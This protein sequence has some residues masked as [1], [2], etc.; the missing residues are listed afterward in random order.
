MN[1]ID[2][3][4][5]IASLLL[6]LITGW[7]S[8]RK[9]NNASDFL[10]AGKS[11]NKIQAGFSMASTDFGGSGLVAA[12]GYCYVVGMSG[13]WWNL[14]AAPAFVL[15]GIFLARQFNTLDGSTL[16]EFLGNRYSV[17]VKNLAAVLH[18]LSN[19]ASLSVQF[20]VSCTVLYVVTGFSIQASLVIS[21]LLVVLL[22]S[23]GLKAVVNTDSI[24]F[25]LI[26]LSV[27]FCIPVM[28]NAAGGMEHIR[29]TVAP[30]TFGISELGVMTPFS[31]IVLCVITYSTNQNYVQRMVASKN[32]GTA[33]FGAFFTAGF[34]L[35][36]SVA[37][38]IIGIA[39]SV[40]MPGVED[41]NSIFAR[42]I[43]TYFPH[44]LIGLGLAG[45]FA[46]TI[47][48]GT[49]IL[50]STTTLIT[51]DLI[52][53]MLKKKPSDR[54]EVIMAKAVAICVALLSM[55][56][57]LMFDNIIDVIYTGGLFYGVAVFVPM[58]FGLKTK[59]VNAKT[60]LASMILSVVFSMLWQYEVIIKAPGLAV[61]PSNVFG[62]CVGLAV[63]LIAY[64][65]SRKTT[66]NQKNN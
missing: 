21:M 13:I 63:M 47:S 34:Y 9:T 35:V 36:I 48:T 43:V 41:S 11:L 22:T 31:W 15:V 1:I 58:I 61:I 16:P 4:I 28:L 33:V 30:E 6:I 18:I 40:A 2:Y 5:L 14:A 60:A 25:V 29:E 46:A 45:V 17:H 59:W 42:I 26:I 44:G 52:G 54:G 38:G 24:L 53:P 20:T 7:L 8:G 3:A 65:N 49:S 23:G 50:H 19:F 10:L 55:V 32:E 62:I 57:S 39:S 27:V 12:L 64:L 56:V 66:S 51:N 37:I